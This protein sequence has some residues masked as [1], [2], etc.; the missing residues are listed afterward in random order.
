MS[1]AVM[2]SGIVGFLSPLVIQFLAKSGWPK[3]KQ[4]V[5]A[6]VFCLLVS[7][8]TVY[9]AGNFEADDL[10]KSALIIFTVAIA[11]YKGFWNPVGVTPTNH[12]ETTGVRR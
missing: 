2:W 4:A 7:I 6:L 10:A 3:A 11:S 5:V 12:A 8:P 1:N 9:F